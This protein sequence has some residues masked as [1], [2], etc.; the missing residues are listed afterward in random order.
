MNVSRNIMMMRI[1]DTYE[2]KNFAYF[3]DFVK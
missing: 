1:M 2:I 3:L